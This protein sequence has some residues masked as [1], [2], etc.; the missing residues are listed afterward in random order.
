[1]EVQ[2]QL[3]IVSAGLDKLVDLTI[4]SGLRDDQLKPGD[5]VSL[6]A[7]VVDPVG[8]GSGRPLLAVVS[9]LGE[10]TADGGTARPGIAGG[11][12]SARPFG[13]SPSRSGG[14]GSSAGPGGAA[15]PGQGS[16]PTPRPPG[17]PTPDFSQFAIEWD[18]IERDWNAA[19]GRTIQLAAFF[20]E[21]N[22]PQET[23]SVHFQ[24]PGTFEAPKSFGVTREPQIH[25]FLAA[26]DHGEPVEFQ[27]VI[28]G[29]RQAEIAWIQRWQ[30][31]KTRVAS[32][33]ARRASAVF[34]D[35]ATG[36]GRISRLVWSADGTMLVSL[37]D[38]SV[39]FW[40]PASGQPHAS[41]PPQ[42]GNYQDIKLSAN[43]AR[44]LL[45][46]GYKAVV[47]DVR[48]GSVLLTAE[49]VADLSAAAFSPNGDRVVLSQSGQ[50]HLYRERD[51]KYIDIKQATAALDNVAD[52]NH[53]AWSD[54]GRWLAFDGDRKFEE[55]RVSQA[56]AI[57]VYR[58]SS[59]GTSFGK[60]SWQPISE[61]VEFL[62]WRGDRLFALMPNQ[63][64]V[65]HD[66]KSPPAIPFANVYGRKLA[67]SPDGSLIAVDQIEQFQRDVLSIYSLANPSLA[68]KLTAQA[69]E[70]GGFDLVRFAPD[71]RRLAVADGGDQSISLYDFS[72]AQVSLRLPT[73]RGLSDLAFSPDGKRL[74]GG[75]Y[76]GTIR[77]WDMPGADGIPAGQ[78]KD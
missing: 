17:G 35:I 45:G 71:N 49:G 55:L 11:P 46:D 28:T 41:A 9:I 36:A 69:L 32:E 59:N 57:F 65:L 1:L 53:V 48:S 63:M 50:L 26:L 10:V 77:I 66:K 7:T 78:T 14:F 23:V 6:E 40:D 43:A 4:P 54:D 31:A 20:Q 64:L 21:F 72:L 16:D 56:N 68:T 30:Q 60:K 39:Q 76:N 61:S 33:A 8:K 75:F 62:E 25:T 5:A 67:V 38:E 42:A 18:A 12:A 19:V 22:I 44:L 34:Q 2:G 3:Q 74:A 47:S 70:V 24:G 52:V 15:E 51:S 13:G 29:N 27:A 58:F 73:P 37:S